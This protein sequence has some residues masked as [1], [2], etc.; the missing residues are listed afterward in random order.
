[1]DWRIATEENSEKE[2]DRPIDEPRQIVHAYDPETG[3]L[4]CPKSTAGMTLRP[5]ELWVDGH[6]PGERC[7]GCVANTREIDEAK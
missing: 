1:M 6:E 2:F 7:P 5:D 3:D 4:A